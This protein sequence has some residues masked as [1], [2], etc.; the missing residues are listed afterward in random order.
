MSNLLQI[1]MS[2]NRLDPTI[3]CGVL[4]ITAADK[5]PLVEV[6]H[7]TGRADNE[8]S[9]TFWGKPP[10]GAEGATLL[11]IQMFRLPG[12]HAEFDR[13]VDF[14]SDKRKKWARLRDGSKLDPAALT[15]KGVPMTWRHDAF[16]RSR[17]DVIHTYISD[18]HA[19]LIRYL[20]DLPDVA[21]FH[22]V[23]KNLRV[24]EGQWE[25]A[26]PGYAPRSNEP[27]ATERPLPAD[28]AKEIDEAARRASATLKLTAKSTPAATLEAILAAVDREMSKR[29]RPP[30]SEAED[31]A[32]D[33]GCLWAQTVCDIAGWQWC[34]LKYPERPVTY[35]IVN[36]DRSRAIVPM[37]YMARQINQR[38][39][40]ADNTT[41]LLFNT[42]KANKLP[43]TRPK[44]YKMLG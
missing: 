17:R 13:L 5:L 9:L 10:Q 12:E 27:G 4:E 39:P 42:L 21:L 28:V 2:E 24:I 30:Q 40:T 19:M 25:L 15:A 36:P 18:R 7:H 20:G 33:L 43:P 3:R 41:L 22:R 16:P 35:A 44:S 6:V 31:L 11:S 1:D 34:E 38:G 23:N 32:L 29:K 14:F 26:P 37:A 8:I